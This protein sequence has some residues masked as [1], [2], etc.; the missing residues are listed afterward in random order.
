VH[1]LYIDSSAGLVIGL[2]DS[3]YSWIEYMS[4]DEKKPSEIIH[5]EIF[6]LLKK[7]NLKFAEMQCFVSSGPGSYTGMRL[8][9]GLAQM[10]ELSSMPV[11]SFC[12]FEVPFFCGVEMGYWATNAFKRQI[13]VYQWE[14][15]KIEKYLVN[16]EDFVIRDE[17]YGFTLDKND[18]IFSN[19]LSTKNLIKEKSVEIFSKV[20]DQKLR[21][22]P[23]YFRTLDEEF[24]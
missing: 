23:F 3:N 11:Y 5:F 4:L 18:P 16:K 2:L 1:S 8:S 22:P 10:F 20:H 9:E 13:F 15:N 17:K 12:H 14:G 7:H 6:N 21:V 19:L 24:N